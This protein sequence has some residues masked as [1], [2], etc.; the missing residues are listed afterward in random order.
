M[1]WFL[2][3]VC[4]FGGIACMVRGRWTEGAFLL[5]LAAVIALREVNAIPDPP[6]SSGYDDDDDW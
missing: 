4:T 5:L 6:S 1:S 3:G 2:S